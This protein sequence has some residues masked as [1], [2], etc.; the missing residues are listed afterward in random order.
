M[1]IPHFIGQATDGRPVTVYGDGTQRRCFCHVSDVVRALVALADCERAYGE[2]INVG[3]QE[4]CSI[5]AL[6]E[7]VIDL[8]G[9]ES[10]VTMIPYEEA[11]EE[12]FED[13][14]R[15]VPELSKIR[16]MIGW[17][18]THALDDIISDVANAYRPTAVL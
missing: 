6:A 16:G 10:E 8:T 4:E 9:S 17:G 7:R 2:V 14:H 5:L 1:V 13:M 12:G 15:R 11:Y 3:S 18:P